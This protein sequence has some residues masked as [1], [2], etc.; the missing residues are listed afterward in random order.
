LGCRVE[1]GK[2]GGLVR[3]NVKEGGGVWPTARPRRDN[4]K[5]SSTGVGERRDHGGG[6]MGKWPVDWPVEKEK[7]EKTGP[8]KATV[9]LSNYL[10]NIP[11]V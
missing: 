11:T 10:K 9:P 2:G 7:K 3:C 5:S 8:A 4:T 1:E 6:R